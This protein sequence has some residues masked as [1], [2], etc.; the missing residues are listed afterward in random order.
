MGHHL[1]AEQRIQAALTADFYADDTGYTATRQY[2]LDRRAAL[3]A[4]PTGPALVWYPTR[5]VTLPMPR[6]TWRAV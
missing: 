3:D 1:T 6:E 5:P 4:L 2:I